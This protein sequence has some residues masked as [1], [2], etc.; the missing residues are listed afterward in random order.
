MIEHYNGEDYS[1]SNRGGIVSSLWAFAI[2]MGMVILLLVVGLCAT[3]YFIGEDAAVIY[4]VAVGVL[5]VVGLL[6]AG[7]YSIM[8]LLTRYG[9]GISRSN[10]DL[11]H[12]H[13]QSGAQQAKMLTEVVRGIN[14]INKADAD[15]QQKMLDS[16]NK[17]GS[18]YEKKMAE[19]AYRL[20]NAE[21]QVKLLSGPGVENDD[22]PYLLPADGEIVRYQMPK[23][24]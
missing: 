7:V 13:S 12:A 19:M 10:A 8:G 20:Q 2:I 14:G 1:Y 11:L 21:Q 6:F 9:L 4:L 22:S 17:I 23:V 24:S 18:V 15:T 5:I 16:W 3:V